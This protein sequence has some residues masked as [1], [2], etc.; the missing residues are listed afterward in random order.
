MRK[1]FVILFISF[2]V[3]A[4]SKVRNSNDAMN[5]AERFVCLQN[6][7]SAARVK[8]ANDII[9]AAS[10]KKGTIFKSSVD[11]AE[12][13]IFNVGDDSGFVIVSGDDDVTDVLGYADKGNFDA[14]NMPDNMKLLLKGYSAQI[15]YIRSIPH[16]SIN[17][18]DASNTIVYDCNAANFPSSVSPLL[19]DMEWGQGYP[20]NMYCPVIRDTVTWTGCVATAMAQTMKY[21][22]WPD[23]GVGHNKY[24]SPDVS[25]S[26][27]VDFSKTH[28]DWNNM[29]ATYG[30]SSTDK[31]KTAVATLMYHC[32][33][34]ADMQYGI[35]GSG[36]DNLN[37]RNC[38]INNFKY[39]SLMNV[40]VSPFYQNYEWESMIKTE[41]VN[42]R[43]VIYGG[44]N[45]SNNILHA[46]VCD[47]YDNSYFHI[48]WGWD[49]LDNGNY[50]LSS[51]IPPSIPGFEFSYNNWMSQ[52]IAPAGKI[53]THK[54]YFI[55]RGMLSTSVKSFKQGNYITLKMDTLV[56]MGLFN[57]FV[58]KV[59]IGLFD[60]HNAIVDSTLLFDFA[61]SHSFRY[62]SYIVH[63]DVNYKLSKQLSDGIYY[64]RP[65][66]KPSDEKDWQFVRR[67]NDNFNYLRL[68]VKSSNVKITTPEDYVDGMQLDSLTL[69]GTSL[70]KGYSGQFKV[71][72][73]NTGDDYESYAAILLVDKNDAN[74]RT[75]FGR[76]LIYMPSGNSLNVEFNDTVKE[77]IGD[78]DAYFI[79]DK[80]NYPMAV[81]EMRTLGT[82]LPVNVV[83]MANPKYVL[84]Q[85]L[86]MPD[87]T[88][89]H[90]DDIRLNPVHIK[91]VG[92][93]Y[94]GNV[95]GWIYDCSANKWICKFSKQPVSLS[96]GEETTVSLSGSATSVPNGNY[97]A[98]VI[99]D[100]LIDGYSQIVLPSSNEKFYVDFT[101]TD[102]TSVTNAESSIQLYVSPEAKTINVS[103]DIPVYGLD[104]FDVTGKK[105]YACRQNGSRNFSIDYSRWNGGAYI[106]KLT[107]SKGVKT[108]KLLINR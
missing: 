37:M 63:D 59:D 29:T 12:I 3:T 91:N 9:L 44:S 22:Q 62:C 42:K 8:A 18:A 43:P 26:L 84:T 56:N 4:E 74:K 64:L 71:K 69:R 98:F 45:I 82:S 46:F 76:K 75:L 106:I 20:Y 66:F 38:M 83:E 67:A 31:Q 50:L 55:Y 35:K 1:I 47:G 108:T 41:L 10:L 30:K 72:L 90:K 65:V 70:C 11:N 39:D 102:A 77:D 49:G 13:Y 32:G 6:E 73:K 48:N 86:S 60:S 23:V 61:P 93:P 15:E 27:Y 92:A 58:G 105:V 36:A 5:V 28:Y 107:T 100:F 51:L 85:S 95:E 54:Q 79:Y 19:G 17:K 25:D 87:T 16:L 89:V 68:V 104:I 96:T 57:S 40:S 81:R 52:N 80:N 14:D 33:V 78:Y 103:S 34:A 94:T 2:F 21:W 53:K 101:L 99:Y 24:K 97:R 7:K 88:N